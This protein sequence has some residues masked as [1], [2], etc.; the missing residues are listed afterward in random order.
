MTLQYAKSFLYIPSASFLDLSMPRKLC[1]GMYQ[2]KKSKVIKLRIR[3]KDAFVVSFNREN[4]L[5][6]TCDSSK[7]LVKMDEPLDP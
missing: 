3:R 1:L 4:G 5:Y 6:W 2:A 7:S